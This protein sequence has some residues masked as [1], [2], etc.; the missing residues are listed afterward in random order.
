MDRWFVVITV[1]L[2]PAP[3]HTETYERDQ[4]P[5]PRNLSVS[6]FFREGAAVAHSAQRLGY[7]LDEGGSF[8]ARGNDGSFFFSPPRPERL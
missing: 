1:Q 6:V 3:V 7:G 5:W 4:T 2:L 8:P